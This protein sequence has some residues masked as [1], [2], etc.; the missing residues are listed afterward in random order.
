[1]MVLYGRKKILNDLSDEF[2]KYDMADYSLL[3]RLLPKKLS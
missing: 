3:N 2:K 1:M